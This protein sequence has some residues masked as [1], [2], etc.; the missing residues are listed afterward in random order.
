M[1]REAC[2]TTRPPLKRGQKAL[3]WS[4]YTRTRGAPGA[5]AHRMGL[6]LEERDAALVVL[7]S[8]GRGSWRRPNRGATEAGGTN[9]RL[10]IRLPFEQGPN[11]YINRRAP[12]RV[13]L[14]FMRSSGFAYLAKALVISPAVPARWMNV[15]D[16]TLDQTEKLS[17]KL[18]VISTG[19]YWD[20]ILRFQPLAV[21]CDQPGRPRDASPRRYGGGRL[22]AAEANT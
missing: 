17:K 10:N 14:F 8:G 3:E 1:K 16:L 5:H 19:E 13:P 20:Q 11:P 9:R 12:P 22:R 4:R 6:S 21:G 15:R 2:R 18:C 7:L